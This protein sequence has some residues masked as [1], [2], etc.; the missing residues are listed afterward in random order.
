MLSTSMNIQSLRQ[1]TVQGLLFFVVVMVY[2]YLITDGTLLSALLT[3]IIGAVFYGVL[4]YF[5]DVY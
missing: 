1:P 5:W 2:E 4:T 3:A